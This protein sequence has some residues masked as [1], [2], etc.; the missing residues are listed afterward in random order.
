MGTFGGPK[1][2]FREKRIRPGQCAPP[3]RL[4]PAGFPAGAGGVRTGS[5]GLGM[6]FMA[7]T[8]GSAAGLE[9]RGVGGAEA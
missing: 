2:P 3:S 9:A 5:G 6:G 8:I 7:T 1:K 4:P